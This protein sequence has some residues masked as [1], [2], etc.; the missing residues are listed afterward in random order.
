M[1]LRDLYI[2]LGSGLDGA[3]I[4]LVD[5]S[6]PENLPEVNRDTVARAYGEHWLRRDQIRMKWGF[7]VA[8]LSICWPVTSF[9]Q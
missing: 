9:T 7:L 8:G 6:N 2:T 1:D 5:T 3:G 4:N